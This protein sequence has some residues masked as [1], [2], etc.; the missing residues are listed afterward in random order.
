VV[1]QAIQDDFC[2]FDTLK[3]LL[4]EAATLPREDGIDKIFLFMP[5]KRWDGTLAAQEGHDEVVRVAARLSGA[6][7]GLVEVVKV[8]VDAV[9][10]WNQPRIMVETD[11]RNFYSAFCKKRGFEH[12]LIV[13][14]DELWRA[15]LMARLG[16]F[17]RDRGWPKSVFTGMIPVAGLPGYPI[18]GALDKATIYARSSVHFKECRGAVGYRHSLPG[19]D[20]YHF[21]ATRRT[22]Q[23]IAD[24]HH[25]SGHKDD[26]RYQMERWIQEVLL[27]GRIKP[28]LRNL[29]MY[30]LYGDNNV[31]PL[32]RA[33]SPEEWAE[34]PDAVKPFLSNSR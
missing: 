4:D 29:H 30:D 20:I 23:E 25:N 1:V 27:P 10:H 17:I 11:C 21:T 16:Q 6:H 28:G 3:R 15:G 8:N 14:G 5:T 12:L 22:L 32:V 19:F 7:P 9:S 2:L 26:A 31:W 33:W 13:D 34:L 18:E 24:K